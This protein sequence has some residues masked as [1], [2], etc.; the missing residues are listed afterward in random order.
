M[1]HDPLTRALAQS[2]RLFTIAQNGLNAGGDC[3]DASRVDQ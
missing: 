3:V 1:P 2:A